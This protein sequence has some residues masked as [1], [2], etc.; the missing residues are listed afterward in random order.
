VINIIRTSEM[1]STTA[2]ATGHDASRLFEV[3]LEKGAR[4]VVVR[5]DVEGHGERYLRQALAY[6]ER[7]GLHLVGVADAEG[8]LRMVMA[9]DADVL[10]AVNRSH[11][12]LPPFVRLVSDEHPQVS[13]SQRRPQRRRAS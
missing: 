9:G 7:H 12:A 2:K 11:V 10:V 4:A 5:H 6:V 1:V 3:G 13:P 8:A